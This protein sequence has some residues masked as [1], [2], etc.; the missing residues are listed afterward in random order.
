MFFILHK[1]KNQDGEPAACRHKKSKNRDGMAFW[2]KKLITLAVFVFASV[3]CEIITFLMMG[4]GLFPRYFLIDLAIILLVA[5]VIFVIPYH[6]ASVALASAIFCGQCLLSAVNV[7][8]SSVF[9]GNF[10][11]VEMLVDTKQAMEA[12][13]MMKFNWL[14]VLP[15]PALFS[16]FL[17]VEILTLTKIK[18]ED[19]S[20][21][22]R[23]SICLSLIFAVC[24]LLSPAAG[25]LRI[26]T[27]PD[28]AA[29]TATGVT[30]KKNFEDMTSKVSFFE[31]FGTFSLFC[32]NFILRQEPGAVSVKAY[33]PE[34][35]ANA[36]AA[37]TTHEYFGIDRGKN[38]IVVM[39]E[40]F[41]H[42]L[43]DKK[44]TP[45]MHEIYSEGVSFSGYHTHNKTD[46]SEA[47]MILG[48]YPQTGTLVAEGGSGSGGI[49]GDTRNT[50]F[51]NEFPFSMPNVLRNNGYEQCNYFIVHNGS[52]YAR[53]YTHKSYGF[54]NVYFNESYPRNP[55]FRDYEKYVWSWNMP[56][57]YFIDSALE[58]LMP[59]DKRFFSFLSLINPHL[60]YDSLEEEGLSRDCYNSI[61]DA[62]FIS[63]RNKVDANTYQL[64]KNAL[65]KAMVAD[66]G[67]EYLLEQLEARGLAGDTT[68]LFYSDHNA[69]GN[70]LTYLVRGDNKRIRPDSYNLPAAIWSPNKKGLEIDKFVNTFD[71]VPTLFEWLGI[72]VDPGH[73][74]GVSAF[75]SE[76]SVVIS[77][78]GGWLFNDK[79]FTDGVNILYEVDG[80]TPQDRE[81]FRAACERTRS[82]WSYIH[83]LF[84]KE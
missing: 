68:I 65:A 5:G 50:K 67:I 13:S 46:V 72:D 11:T 62:D 57:E 76:E 7:T 4:I 29:Q 69:Y 66:R 54:D 73:Y 6:A 10:L 28:D 47:I 9:Y 38:V 61:D 39:T 48:N 63:L 52:Y 74:L 35:Q 83:T 18:G 78:F 81:R 32:K 8:L 20:F 60:P 16:A 21:N 17:A 2:H 31:S 34:E 55:K 70:D 64:Y 51:V 40:S 23:N 45:K 1:V 42:I 80:V 25:F 56:E 15:F 43:L 3:F 58:D 19:F 36:R 27:L 44:Y 14:L 84:L 49:R 82:K 59:T 41:D 26:Y 33:R 24:C 77:G 22:K 37:D 12:F 30:H 53:Q 75:E 79:F 71:L